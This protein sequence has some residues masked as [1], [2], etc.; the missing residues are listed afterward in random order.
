MTEQLGKPVDDGEAQT[1][2]AA[3]PAPFL[4]LNALPENLPPLIR[5]NATAGIPHLDPHAISAPATANQDA[6]AIGIFDGIG[7][8]IA[9]NPAEQLRIASCRQTCR[10][11]S[12]AETLLRRLH[13]KRIVDDVEQVTNADG[14]QPRP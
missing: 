9:E 8:E 11:D 6:A 7:N 14:G 5:R 12:E 10:H 3:R 2:S 4:D 13:R 1:Q